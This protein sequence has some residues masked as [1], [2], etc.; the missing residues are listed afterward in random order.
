M[1]EPSGGAF[2]I[3]VLTVSL[4]VLFIVKTI[5]AGLQGQR[6]WAARQEREYVRLQSI[7]SE[8]REGW[9]SR[10]RGNRPRGER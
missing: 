2:G 6:D 5:Q 8:C 10:N 4:M 9:N 7:R 3:L 1:S